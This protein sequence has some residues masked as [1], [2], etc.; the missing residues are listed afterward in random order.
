[1]LTTG[2]TVNVAVEMIAFKM[3]STGVSLRVRGVQVL[4]YLPYKPASPFDEADGFTADQ[5]KSLFTAAED[6]DMFEGEGQIT[7]QPDLF[8]DAEDEVSE[9]AE[10]VKRKKK[11]EAA[12][13]VEEEM[14][15]I[16]DIWGDED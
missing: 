14:A 15:D 8:D 3:A 7:K 1:M 6:D 11:K 4:K 5:S 9:V 2:S 10:P 16:I 12:P 13:A